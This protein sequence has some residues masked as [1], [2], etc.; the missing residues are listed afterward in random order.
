M[1][2]ATQFSIFVVNKPG[3]MD[4]VTHALADAGV[5]L[6]AL[7][8]SDSGEH[9]VL[10]ILC[11]DADKARQVLRDTHDRW[12]E[13]DVIVLPMGNEPGTFAGFTRKLAEAGININYA[14]A[15][16]SE[17]GGTTTAVFKVPDPQAAMAALK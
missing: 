8:L 13:T 9:G 10:R 7:S 14:Y 4:A 6:Y 11:D 15:T 1:H 16:A 3:V 17:E 2:I 12:T 5:N